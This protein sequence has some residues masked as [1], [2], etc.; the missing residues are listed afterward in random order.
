MTF[1]MLFYCLAKLRDF[2]F[3]EKTSMKHT[4]LIILIV[5][6]SANIFAQKKMTDRE[7]ANLKGQVKS[8]LNESVELDTPDE[9]VGPDSPR[10]DISK[11]LYDEAGNITQIIY[12]EGVSEDKFSIVNG[13][14]T[15]KSLSAATIYLYKYAYDAK[16]RIIE[17]EKYDKSGVLFFKS[18][19]KYS[20]KG[21]R[22]EEIL[23]AKNKMTG[24]NFYTYNAQGNLTDIKYQ[25]LKTTHKFKDY[26]L[27][28]Q[29][30]WIER[31]QT[32]ISSLDGKQ[33]IETKILYR[34]IQYY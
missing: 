29:G 3:E 8:V 18:V 10:Q 32:T 34:T 6:L 9:K 24:D 2:D 5:I 19:Y 33:Y 23:Y 21:Q 28:P 30:N 26:K 7:F 17:E 27:D 13:V 15:Q 11:E 16:G 14:K 20:E 31:T 12:T 1:L 25:I 22:N 4:L